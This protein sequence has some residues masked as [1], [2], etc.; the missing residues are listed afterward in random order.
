[1]RKQN[2]IERMTKEELRAVVKE[3]KRRKEI[4]V[5]IVLRQ[6]S[7]TEK[8]NAPAARC[9]EPKGKT[10]KLRPAIPKQGP[11]IGKVKLPETSTKEFLEYFGK[12]DFGRTKGYT[13]KWIAKRLKKEDTKTV[14]E[15]LKVW[16]HQSRR[17]ECNERK[18][19]ELNEMIDREVIFALRSLEKPPILK[20]M[21]NKQL[22]IRIHLTT[23]DTTKSFTKVAL[24]DLGCTSSCISRKFIQENGINT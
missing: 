5:P 9:L 13:A 11:I 24:I 23:I 22:D 4:S 10:E 12:R 8:E 16:A 19:R 17:D 6:G 2:M 3:I 7:I 20:Q 21:G 1:M 18:V 14:I 15:I